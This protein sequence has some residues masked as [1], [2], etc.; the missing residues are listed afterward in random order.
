VKIK[1]IFA[2]NLFNNFIFIFIFIFIFNPNSFPYIAPTDL[3]ILHD[4]SE[5]CSNRF[6]EFLR[7]SW[8]PVFRFGVGL[9]LYI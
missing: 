4:N 5:F 6:A 3:L 9:W 7:D 8:R 1:Y 2:K